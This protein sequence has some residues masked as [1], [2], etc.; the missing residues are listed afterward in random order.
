MFVGVG[1]LEATK[2]EV[3]PCGSITTFLELVVR[4]RVEARRAYETLAKISFGG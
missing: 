1:N 3:W 4:S 2:A